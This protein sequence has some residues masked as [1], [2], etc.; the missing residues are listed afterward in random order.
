MNAGP[1]ARVVSVW[2]FSAMIHELLLLI[3]SP[4]EMYGV[5]LISVVVFLSLVIYGKL[6]LRAA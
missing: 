6:K 2:E 1:R 3:H 5:Y 4:D